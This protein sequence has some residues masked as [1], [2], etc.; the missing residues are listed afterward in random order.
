MGLGQSQHPFDDKKVSDV[1]CMG[2]VIKDWMAL[3]N[4][5]IERLTTIE[6]ECSYNNSFTAGNLAEAVESFL[7]SIKSSRNSLHHVVVR[8]IGSSLIQC[9]QRYAQVGEAQFLAEWALV[10]SS[11]VDVCSRKIRELEGRILLVRDQLVTKEARTTV[12]A[13]LDILIVLRNDLGSIVA[14]MSDVPLVMRASHG[15][16]CSTLAWK[17]AM[18]RFAMLDGCPI[19]YI[20]PGGEKD[21]ESLIAEKMISFVMPW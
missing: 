11:S 12:Q 19:Q 5:T 4:R 1:M 20:P 2:T 18:C 7:S 9:S 13:I 16:Q 3:Q 21:Y 6:M 15:S 8:G 14:K 10:R 17:K